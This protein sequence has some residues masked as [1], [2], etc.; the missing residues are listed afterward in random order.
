MLNGQPSVILPVLIGLLLFGI[1]FNLFVA[2][3]GIRQ[4]GYTAL[5][6]V[7]GVSV[8]LIAAIPVVGLESA[9]FIGLAFACSGLPMILGDIWRA[10]RERERA[11]QLS[12]QFITRLSE[13]HDDETAG[14][15][16]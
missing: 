10:I 9:L 11:E 2:W 8:T 5:L 1:L 6:V 16:Q 15:A 4:R 7:I 14:L 3:L 12:R 13:V